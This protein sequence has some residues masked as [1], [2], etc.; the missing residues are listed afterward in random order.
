M[1][2]ATATICTCVGAPIAGYA[3]AENVRRERLGL[4]LDDYRG[5]IGVILANL[6]A[7]PFVVRRGDRIAQMVIAPVTQ[8]AVREAM[9]T[10]ETTRGAGGFGSTGVR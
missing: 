6:G 3:I 5:E 7:E 2:V 9:E 10:S 8:V 4:S 1:V